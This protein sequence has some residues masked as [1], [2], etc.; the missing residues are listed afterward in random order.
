MKGTGFSYRTFEPA[1]GHVHVGLGRDRRVRAGLRYADHGRKKYWLDM[2]GDEGDAYGRK[3]KAG[4]AARPLHAV[5][6]FV[7]AR[8]DLREGYAPLNAGDASGVIKHD[9]EQPRTG[10][11]DEYEG[12]DWQRWKKQRRL[13]G[14]GYHSDGSDAESLGFGEVSEDDDA[15]KLYSDAKRLEFG[16]H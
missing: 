4:L 12:D 1:E 2:P 8:M 3:G 10:L 15:E 5:R 7:E 16:E 6:K 11:G 9:E 14:E 13:E